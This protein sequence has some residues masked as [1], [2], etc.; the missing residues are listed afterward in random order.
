MKKRDRAPKE[1]HSERW[2]GRRTRN[3]SP[4]G[5]TTFNPVFQ[6]SLEPIAKRAA[7]SIRMINWKTTLTSLERKMYRTVDRKM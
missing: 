7:F 3:W 2:S 6:R 1:R 4:V 5:S